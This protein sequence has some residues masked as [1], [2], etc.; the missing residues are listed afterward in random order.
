MLPSWA[1]QLREML[2][3]VVKKIMTKPGFEGHFINHSLRQSTAK[4]RMSWVSQMIQYKASF[5]SN[6][7][8]S[9][10]MIRNYNQAI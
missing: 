5:A 9:L 4:W 7:S 3:N 6:G 2:W 8:H 1:V 10:N